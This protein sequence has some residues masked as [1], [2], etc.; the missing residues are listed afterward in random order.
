MSGLINYLKKISWIKLS[1]I[2]FSVIFFIFNII[3]N[4]H[5]KHDQHFSVLAESFLQ[6]KLYFLE[7]YSSW[8]H[9]AVYFNGHYY[10]PQGPLPAV[11]LMPFVFLFKSL[12]IPFYQS[13]VQIFF[14]LGVYFLIYKISRKLRY[15]ALDSLFLAFAFT[16]ATS[17]IGV[18]FWSTGWFFSQVVATF[19]LL[20]VIKEY[21]TEKRLWVMG[22]LFGLILLTRVTAFLGIVFV[23]WQIF[24]DKGKNIKQRA[25]SALWLTS[26]VIPFILIF[27]AYNWPRFGS[28]F[29]QG[30]NL[31]MIAGNLSGAKSYGLFNTVHLPG[32]LYY[33][34]IAPPEPVFRDTFS[35]VLIYPFIK[36]NPWGL[37]ILFTS[38]YL[39]Y[40]FFLRYKGKISAVLLLTVFVIAIPVFTYYGIG[41][42]Q[43]GYR[44]SLDFMPFL[45]LLFMNS[46]RLKYKALSPGLR[47]MI[48]FSGIFD[49]FL[50]STIFGT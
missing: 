32:N 11:I 29:E 36:A 12:N 3:Y 17:F 24:L 33:F 38:P 30:Y 50:F 5:V 4:L 26:V 31:Q 7:Q 28:L 43:F 27:G 25:R 48:I 47:G 37:G 42:Y 45:F 49:L 20:A 35:H 8:W 6:G 9:D 40:L 22:I 44:Y 34:L 46:Y 15:T 1:I 16:F 14:C 21:V 10:W 39:I 41:W 13:Y 18:S 2:L 19:L 23:F